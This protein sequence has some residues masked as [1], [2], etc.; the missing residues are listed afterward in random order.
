MSNTNGN[1]SETAIH[2]SLQGKGGVGKSLLASILAQYFSDRHRTVRCM[3]TDPVNRTLSQYRALQVERIQLVEDGNRINQRGFDVLMERFLTESGVTFVVDNGASTFLPLWHYM[4]EN[5]ALGLLRDEG[6]QIYV[7][8][9][10]TGGQALTDTLNGFAALAKTA[11]DRST[12]GESRP[13][14][15]R[16]MKW[17]RTATTAARSPARSRSC[18]GTPTRS[19]GMSRRWSRGS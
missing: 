11:E 14:G 15:N 16:S 3:D 13:R 2:L 8:T 10:V 1:S 5:N 12:S 9:V 17:R 19:A 18:G 4:L 6:R 7:H